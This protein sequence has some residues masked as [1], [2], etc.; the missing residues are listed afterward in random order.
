M[1][2]DPEAL[3]QMAR[4]LGDESLRLAAAEDV[5]TEAERRLPMLVD[6]LLAE[7]AASDDVVDRESALAFLADRL[8]FLGPLLSEDQRERVWEALVAKVEAW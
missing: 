2:E 7:A 1:A 4:L 8:A 3:A 6:G 5:R